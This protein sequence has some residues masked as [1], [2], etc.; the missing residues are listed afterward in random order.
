MNWILEAEFETIQTTA[1]K[2]LTRKLSPKDL[3]RLETCPSDSGEKTS[4]KAGGKNSKNNFF[5]LN[6]NK[7]A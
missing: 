5:F 6:A 3:M 7:S 1:P 4:V 2:K